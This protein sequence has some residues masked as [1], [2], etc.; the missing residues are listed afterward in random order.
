MTNNTEPLD[1]V[2]WRAPEWIQM[3]GLRTDNVLEYFAQ[4]P[5]YD[6][7]SNNQVLKMQSQF[8]EGLHGRPDL[9]RELRNMKGIEFIVVLQ[10]EPEMWVIRKQNR[11]TPHEARVLATYFVVGENIYMA[12]SI[13]SI[14]SSRLLATANSL[15][16]ALS[17]S[18][19]LPSY[20]PSK[21]YSYVNDVQLTANNEESN[22][23]TPASTASGTVSRKSN[24]NLAQSKAKTPGSYGSPAIPQTPGSGNTSTGNDGQATKSIEMALAF[25]MSNSTVYI[26]PFSKELPGA[27]SQSGDIRKKRKP[28]SRGRVLQQ[29]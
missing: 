29:N 6:R 13:Y 24:Q 2:Q 7:T 25:T 28:E 1:E 27:L 19:S 11:L 22:S 26:D 21:G 9:T 17:K 18:M 23:S 16:E 3:F 15:T 10:K 4:S 14:V 8:N 20:S 5:F 12:P